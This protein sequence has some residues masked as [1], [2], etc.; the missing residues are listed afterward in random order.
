M[1]PTLVLL[2]AFPLTSAMWAAQR[3]ALAGVCRLVVPNQRGFGGTPLGT[4][5]PEL[6]VV[7]AD[8]AL[9]LDSLGVRRAYVGGLSMGGY[10]ALAFLRRYPERVAGLV[11]AD[12]KAAADPPEAAEN[13]RRIAAEVE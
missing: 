13:R 12:T 8:V 10:V 1:T 4:A 3:E 5:P 7:A 6:G 2:H 11:L 9:L